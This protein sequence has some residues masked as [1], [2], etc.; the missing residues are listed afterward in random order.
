MRETDPSRRVVMTGRGVISP[1]GLNVPEFWDSMVAN[2]SGIDFLPEEFRMRRVSV[3]AMVKNYQGIDRP[4]YHR[5]VQF[6]LTGADEALTEAGLLEGDSIVGAD[7]E[8]IS[9]VIGTGW[10]GASHVGHMQ[11]LLREGRRL[12]RYELLQ[13]IPCRTALVLAMR[14]PVY[15]AAFSINNACASFGAAF[16]QA[17]QMLKAGDAKVVITGGAE[18][19][20]NKLGIAAFDA[21]SALSTSKYPEEACRPFNREGADGFVLGEGGAFFI[22][23]TLDHVRQR[24]ALDKIIG[25]VLG[26]KHC[27]DSLRIDDPRDLEEMGLEPGYKRNPNVAPSIAG[28]IVVMNGALKNAELRPEDIDV[29]TTHTPGTSLG[30]LNESL[31]AVRVF[32][33][34]RVIITAGKD[35][36][37]HMIAGDG[38][39]LISA[40]KM[41]E[42]GIVPRINHLN[43]SNVLDIAKKLNL[44]M[45]RPRRYPVGRLRIAMFTQ[46]GFGGP[47]VA[48]IIE[49]DPEGYN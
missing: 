33:R 41:L 22:L 14:R 19:C 28:A 48:I 21:Q 26:Y 31:A 43:K 35:R 7:P 44:V 12:S 1:I 3:G 27:T 6:V 30:N 24:G 23:E 18:A 37:G 39:R 8:D 29:L 49:K 9:A 17:V 11:D 5:V 2:R 15:N 4:D 36:T 10:G 38:V 46:Y 34:H 13:A 45:A 25:E 16:I 32:G 42:T 20:V 47:A 40:S